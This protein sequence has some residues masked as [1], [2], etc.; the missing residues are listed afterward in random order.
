[1]L[2]RSGQDWAGRDCSG[3]LQA[4]ARVHPGIRHRCTAAHFAGWL[5]LGPATQHP[6]LDRPGLSQQG[7]EEEEAAE[8]VH[9]I[10][11]ANGQ[12]L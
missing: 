12:G 4:A 6:C 10:N 3:L 8:A 5:R 1:M 2:P 11:P 9:G 7:Q